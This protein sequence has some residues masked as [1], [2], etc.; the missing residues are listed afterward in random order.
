MKPIAHAKWAIAVLIIHVAIGC[1]GG[2][3]EPLLKLRFP[4]VEV[5]SIMRR[6]C[7]DCHSNETIWPWYTGCSDLSWCRCV[8]GA[9]LNTSLGIS[10][11]TTAQETEG[12][13]G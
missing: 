7:Y 5:R 8:R 10:A 12:K 9:R 4:P 2:S 13:L 11:Q 3:D 1:A 6:A